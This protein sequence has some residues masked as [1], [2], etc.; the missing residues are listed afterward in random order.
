MTTKVAIVKVSYVL[1]FYIYSELFN[2][3]LVSFNLFHLNCDTLTAGFLYNE[4]REGRVEMLSTKW[5]CCAVHLRRSTFV[6]VL[7]YMAPWTPRFSSWP[8]HPFTA[9]LTG[10]CASF[11]DKNAGCEGHLL[12]NLLRTRKRSLF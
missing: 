5:R 3:F 8:T 9:A 7:H 2:F 6:A 4:T 12:T 10:R 11:P 1:S